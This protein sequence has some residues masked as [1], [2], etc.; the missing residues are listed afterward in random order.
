MEKLLYLNDLLHLE[1]A[2]LDNTKIRFTQPSGGRDPLGEYQSDPDL[3]NVQAF[4]WRST[5]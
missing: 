1:N 4:F 2:D 5:Q 3:I